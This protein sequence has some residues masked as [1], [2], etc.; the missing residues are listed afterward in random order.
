MALSSDFDNGHEP[1]RVRAL[2]GP[3]VRAD[4][5]GL[6]HLRTIQFLIERLCPNPRRKSSTRKTPL[7]PGYDPIKLPLVVFVEWP[8]VEVI[9][10]DCTKAKLVYRISKHSSKELGLTRMDIH[11]CECMGNLIE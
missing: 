2:R 11:V 8:P 6:D 4:R 1:S 7:L 3:L 5:I 10:Y 9:T